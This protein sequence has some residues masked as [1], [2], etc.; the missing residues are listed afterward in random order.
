[1][2][3]KYPQAAWRWPSVDGL[4]DVSLFMA[5][6]EGGIIIPI[7]MLSKLRPEKG[8]SLSKSPGLP[9]DCDLE[10]CQGLPLKGGV[11]GS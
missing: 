10:A 1:M 8:S 5:S 6:L 4:N 9:L 7:L 11:C 3:F 2:G